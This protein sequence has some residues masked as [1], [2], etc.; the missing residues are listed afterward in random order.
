MNSQP[1][2]PK[3]T[4]EQRA[5]LQAVFDDLDAEFDK[6]GAQ[7]RPPTPPLHTNALAKSFVRHKAVELLTNKDTAKKYSAN[8]RTLQ[9]Y[10]ELWVEICRRTGLWHGTDRGAQV[11]GHPWAHKAANQPAGGTGL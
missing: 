2:P 10:D 5:T 3:F 1:Q 9:E 7:F 6:V 11:C 4:P 8:L